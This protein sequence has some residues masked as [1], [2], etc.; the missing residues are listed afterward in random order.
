MQS[1]YSRAPAD[2]AINFVQLLLHISLSVPLESFKEMPVVACWGGQKEDMEEEKVDGTSILKNR[3]YIQ[4]K[5]VSTAGRSA[6]LGPRRHSPKIGRPRRQTINLAP[7]RRVRACGDGPRGSRMPVKA[8]LDRLPLEPG[9]TRPDPCT[10]QH[11]RPKRVP[12]QRVPESNEYAPL[13]WEDVSLFPFIQ[14]VGT[15]PWDFVRE[16]KEAVMP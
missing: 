6:R 14:M 2:W 7:P 5:S 10:D 12:A 4:N 15:R 16:G 11:G 3:T 9:H 13:C 1:V 8:H